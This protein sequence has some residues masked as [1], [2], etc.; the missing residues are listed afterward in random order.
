MPETVKT[1]PSPPSGMRPTC[2]ANCCPLHERPIDLLFIGT[3]NPRRQEMIR[4]IE[5]AGTPV[6]LLTAPCTAPSAMPWC[7]Q[8]KA[9]STAISTRPL[10]FE[11][12]RAFQCLSLGT[13]MI[14]ELGPNTRPP[15]AFAPCVTWLR[16]ED[17][18]DFF[19]HT[20][21]PKPIRRR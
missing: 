14:T 16:D 13:P 18:S 15:E 1:C 7:V 8:A 17:L 19:C 5:A 9:S 3:M 21:T 2:P 10:A 20:S 12:V 6:T 4:R 11:Q